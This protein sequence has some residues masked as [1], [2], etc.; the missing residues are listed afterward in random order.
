MPA[1]TICID[2]D[3]P[4][5]KAS[6]NAGRPSKYPFGDLATNDSFAVPCRPSE[7]DTVL[8]RMRNAACGWARRNGLRRKFVCRYRDQ[9]EHGR[10]IDPEVRV[11]RTDRN[12]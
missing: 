6:S 8:T 2:S 4:L 1:M 12:K 3:I 7:V 11:W 10:A 5:P 9:D